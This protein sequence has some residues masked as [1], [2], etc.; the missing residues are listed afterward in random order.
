MSVVNYIDDGDF[1]IA[2]VNGS[3]DV[4]FPF[5]S[6]GDGTTWEWKPRL[7]IDQDAY[8]S[9]NGFGAAYTYKGV[10]YLVNYKTLLGQWQTPLGLGY[11]LD[12][13]S[14]TDIGSGLYEFTPTIGPVPVNRIVGGTISTAIQVF[15]GL[16]AWQYNDT[17]NAQRLIE[18]GLT[19]FQPYLKP[20]ITSNVY[21]AI[22][23]KGT[24]ATFT[25]VPAIPLLS[26]VP[27]YGPN[28]TVTATAF[29]VDTPFQLGDIIVAQDSE[30]NNYK[31]MYKRETFFLTFP[32]LITLKPAT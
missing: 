22:V 5:I 9:A 30:C 13:G 4:G 16:A 26:G 18:Y 14:P 11:M 8:N 15:A 29:P 28:I 20:K 27:V 3:P 21:G 10:T 1:T 17:V 24:W 23:A 6:E 2:Y 31:A 7:R 19:P 12:F 25:F 32:N